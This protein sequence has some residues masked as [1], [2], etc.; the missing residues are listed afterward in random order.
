MN[1]DEITRFARIKGLNLVGTGDFTHPRWLGELKEKLVEIPD[2][3]LY[4]YAKDP[5]SPI[6]YMITNEVSTIFTF[7]NEVKKIHHVILTPSLE[8]AVQIN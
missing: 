6:R 4:G 2:T 7:K 5:D 3:N 1:I 8:T